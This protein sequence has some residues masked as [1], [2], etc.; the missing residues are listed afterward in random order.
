MESLDSRDAVLELVLE[1]L[2]EPEFQAGP[3]AGIVL[4]AYLR[5]SPATLDSDPRVDRRRRRRPRAR[6]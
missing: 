2:A 6:R 4:Q 5:D 1:L 3:S